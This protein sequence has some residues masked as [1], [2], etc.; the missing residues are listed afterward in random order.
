MSNGDYDQDLR[1]RGAMF[2][3]EYMS[4]IIEEHKSLV[5][6]H[7]NIDPQMIFEKLLEILSE[8]GVWKSMIRQGTRKVQGFLKR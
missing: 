7:T 6:T 2:L 4:A 3:K 5:D 8:R 1:R